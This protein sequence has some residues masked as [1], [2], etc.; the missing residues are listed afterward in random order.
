MSNTLLL[1]VA[2]IYT[3]VA[4]DYYARGQ[5]GMS[6]AF[7]AYAVSNLGFILHNTQK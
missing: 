5:P 7:A 1:V 6:L 3:Y 2:C 4:Y